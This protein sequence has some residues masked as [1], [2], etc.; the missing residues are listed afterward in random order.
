VLI[1]AADEAALYIV[2]S[3][4]RAAAEAEMRAVLGR[5]FDAL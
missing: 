3:D 5:M 4:D 1:A 2:G